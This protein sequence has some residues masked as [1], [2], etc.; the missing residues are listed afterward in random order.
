MTM[1]KASIFE[2]A[3]NDST[4]RQRLS[5]SEGMGDNRPHFFFLAPHQLDDLEPRADSRGPYGGSIAHHCA[6]FAT[7]RGSGV[8]TQVTVRL[9]GIPAAISA[10][11]CSFAS[12]EAEDRLPGRRARREAVSVMRAIKRADRPPTTS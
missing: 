1:A 12:I 8:I 2:V 9:S 10:V 6:L 4:V 7:R 11:V 5:L 3:P